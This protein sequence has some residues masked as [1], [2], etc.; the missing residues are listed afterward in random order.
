MRTRPPPAATTA[1]RWRFLYG[2]WRCFII[3]F[4]VL[5]RRCRVETHVN[6]QKVHTHTLSHTPGNTQYKVKRKRGKEGK[7]NERGKER[8]QASEKGRKTSSL[9]QGDRQPTNNIQPVITGFQWPGPGQQS[10]CRIRHQSYSFSA[11]NR[12]RLFACVMYATSPFASASASSIA[13]ARLRTPPRCAPIAVSSYAAV[14]VVAK[15]N[16]AGF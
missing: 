8:K 12:H 2:D 3:I 7:K 9:H 15:I 11:L 6:I 5:I 10:A 14:A 16:G 4:F 13:S 1:A